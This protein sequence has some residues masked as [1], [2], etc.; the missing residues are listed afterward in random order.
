MTA[1]GSIVALLLVVSPLRVTAAPV[2]TPAP[3]PIGPDAVWIPDPGFMANVHAACD[4]DARPFGDCFLAEMEKAGASPAALAF[5]R[6]TGNQGFM[7]AFHETGPVDIA[8]AEYPYRANENEVCLLV[9]GEPPWIDVDDSSRLDLRALQEN[10]VYAQIKVQ[11]PGVT[12]FPGGRAGARSPQAVR[13]NKGGQRVAVGY[14]LRDGCHAC[15]V[16]GVVLFGFDF[17]ADGR[18]LGTRL[19]SVRAKPS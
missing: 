2:P 4:R 15:A 6:R 12:V 10:R 11:H 9:N 19:M 3:E 1:L 17:D 7:T 18:F 13:L 14:V 5:A 16:V 8:W